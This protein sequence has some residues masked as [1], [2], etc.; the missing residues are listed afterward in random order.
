MSVPNESLA[1]SLTSVPTSTEA[2]ASFENSH[3]N[4]QILVN[5][6]S[7]S[8]VK[9][10]SN[11]EAH[12]T[13]SGSET[14]DSKVPTIENKK[15]QK[16]KESILKHADAYFCDENLRKLRAEAGE[17]K[18]VNIEDL[19]KFEPIEKN[20]VDRDMIIQAF[21]GSENLF[22]I[23]EDGKQVCRNANAK[24][25]AP[26]EVPFGNDHLIH[27]IYVKGFASSITEKQL[28][29][30]FSTKFQSFTRLKMRLDDEGK[31]KGS[32]FVRFK[33]KESAMEAL[34]NPLEFDDQPLLTMLKWNYCVK[35]NIEKNRPF[36]AMYHFQQLKNHKK[37]KLS[38]KEK[39]RLSKRENNKQSN[40]AFAPRSVT[41]KQQLTE[42]LIK[43]EV[44]K[45]DT[46]DSQSPNEGENQN[47]EDAVPILIKD[48]NESVSVTSL[49]R[50]IED[51]NV[52]N[53][54]DQNIKITKLTHQGETSFTT[55]ASSNQTMVEN[56]HASAS[57]SKRKL[58]EDSCEE[59]HTEKK[60]R[61][62][63]IANEETPL[64]K[65]ESEEIIVE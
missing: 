15:S 52:E 47:T 42:K 36:D 1:E 62:S 21:Q 39:K 57:P 25:T 37:P 19:M 61:S 29:E 3:S 44:L 48:E 6:L 65:E 41:K 63:K 8:A 20:S 40:T 43:S 31:F 34:E 7:E 32:V 12:N 33:N 16:D 18:W 30:Y 54:S 22:E 9:G 26:N 55:T 49:K 56:D 11:E 50:K 58:D 24:L 28:T 51:D 23:S 14:E 2:L 45:K 17:E 35:K 38:K 59:N 4:D 53:G 60:T 10:N 64:N 27:S 46:V 13:P 5:E